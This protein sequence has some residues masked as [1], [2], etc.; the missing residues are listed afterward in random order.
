[1]ARRLQGNCSKCDTYNSCTTLT[2]LS[3]RWLPVMLHD[4][5]A[6]SQGMRVGTCVTTHVSHA[7]ADVIT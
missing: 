4:C 7:A 2:V 5:A 1:M 6:V 3:L